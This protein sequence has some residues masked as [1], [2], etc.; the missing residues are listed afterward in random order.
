[1]EMWAHGDLTSSS[2]RYVALE[3]PKGDFSNQTR[4][5]Y[6]RKK[7]TIFQRKK[8]Y[9]GNIFG[10]NED[11]DEALMRPWRS[12]KRC[13]LIRRGICK[14]EDNKDHAEMKKR[15]NRFRIQQSNEKQ[16]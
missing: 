14:G 8:Y 7:S 10:D 5:I 15:H 3:K 12:L 16:N 9:K 11:E 13:F 6:A 1:M 4:N 2:K